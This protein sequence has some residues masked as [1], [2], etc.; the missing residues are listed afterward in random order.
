MFR[1]Q[2]LTLTVLSALLGFGCADAVKPPT[3]SYPSAD[4][5][6]KAENNCA[7]PA[8]DADF[9]KIQTWYERNRNFADAIQVVDGSCGSGAAYTVSKSDGIATI[10][11]EFS[12]EADKDK[13][14]SRELSEDEFAKIEAAL[15][16]V[17]VSQL[18]PKTCQVAVSGCEQSISLES[19]YTSGKYIAEDQANWSDGDGFVSNDSFQELVAALNSFIE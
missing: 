14:T 6:P 17:S 8:S 16:N 13:S 5:N 7:G 15:A 3:L 19:D 2:Y 18:S 12:A 1:R 10:S 9:K 4:G 11:V